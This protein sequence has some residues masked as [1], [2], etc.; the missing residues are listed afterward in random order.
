MPMNIASNHRPAFSVEIHPEKN[1]QDLQRKILARLLL[2][3]WVPLILVTVYFLFQYNAVLSQSHRLRMESVAENQANLLN[4]FLRERIT[5]LINIID[6][7]VFPFPPTSEVMSSCLEDLKKNSDTYVDVGFFDSSGTQ[8]EYAGPFPSLHRRDYSLEPW[9]LTLKSQETN[10]I[11]TDD[12]LG[13]RESP[14]FTIAVSRSLNNQFYV[15]RATLDPIKIYEYVASSHESNEANISILNSRGYYQIVSPHLGTLLK[16]S[17]II[18][19]RSPK[20][21]IERLTIAGKKL[22]YAYS[23]LREADWALIVQWDEQKP[24]QGID[25][26]LFA[27]AALVIAVIFIIILNRAQRLT[28]F[29]LER[30]QDHAQLLHA[31]KLASVG[32]LSAGI[33]HEINNPLAII[34]EEAGLMKDV[35][36]P[37]FEDNASTDELISHLD[38]IREA[39]FRCRDI[40]H[41][42]LEFV[43]KT[44]VK[45]DVYDL[46]SLIDEVVEGLIGREMVLSNITIKKHYAGDLPN[47]QTD[48]SELQ[49]VLL[50]L[51]T[52]AKDA[53]IQGKGLITLETSL[54]DKQ[55]H[56]AISDSGRGMSPSELEKIFLPFYT[57]KEIG[58]GTGLGLSVSY[59][60]IK[61]L[62]GKLSVKSARGKGSTFTIVLPLHKQS[63]LAED[64]NN[65][66]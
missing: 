18:P 9:F 17:S 54:K 22:T 61:H 55:I 44:D 35:L 60:I 57:T 10:S 45:F 52:N 53:I 12:Y 46:H 6:N 66:G 30:E 48:K 15:L 36:N 4:L 2:T 39:A 37:E 47:I 20:T 34:T 16:A 49:Q 21:G 13:F 63:F 14:H 24:L 43:R 62:G 7:P 40:T 29:Q 51:L 32:E 26:T 25:L 64:G 59:G 65:G 50:N 56:I 31:S 3:Y 5:K 41:K 38:I 58:K 42:L 11:I 19:P 27:F 28:A 1:H 8:L 23:W 33:A